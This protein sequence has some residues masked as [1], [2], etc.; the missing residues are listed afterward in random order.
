MATLKLRRIKPKLITIKSAAKQLG[1]SEQMVRL[2]MQQKAIDI[3]FVVKSSKK[4]HVYRIFQ[5]KVNKYLEEITDRE[6]TVCE[7]KS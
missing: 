3:G 1:L 5:H 6:V 7:E 2:A 4:T